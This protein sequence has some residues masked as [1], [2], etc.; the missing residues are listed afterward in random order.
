MPNFHLDQTLFFSKKRGAN[1]IVGQLGCC[2]ACQ[3][4]PSG[5]GINVL[6]DRIFTVHLL[7]ALFARPNNVTLL[8]QRTVYLLTGEKKEKLA[9]L[10]SWGCYRASLE[11]L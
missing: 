4:M 5:A 2:S 3:V 6:A 10:I 9:D 1:T 7:I 8:S 11:V